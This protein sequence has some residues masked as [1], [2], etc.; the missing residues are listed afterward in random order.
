MAKLKDVRALAEYTAKDVSGSPQDCTAAYAP[1]KYYF[2][3]E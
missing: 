3:M 2:K 1:K